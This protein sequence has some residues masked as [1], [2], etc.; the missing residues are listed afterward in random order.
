MHW[1]S[2][3]A[4][5]T[6]GS[7]VWGGQKS[8]LVGLFYEWRALGGSSTANIDARTGVL[9][10]AVSWLVGHR[11]P[12][13]HI[14]APAPGSSVTSDF[15]TIRYSI[16]PDSGRAISGRWV[17]YSL[18]GGDTWTAAT[19]AVCADSGCI[20]DLAGSLGGAPTPNSNGVMLRVRVADDGSPSLSSNAE[21]SA[22]FTL[23]RTGGD[24]RGPVLVAG[25][26]SCSP[27][28]IH[29][30]RPASLFATFSDAAMGGGAVAAA[31][32]SIGPTPTLAGSGTP[33]SGAFGSNTTVSVS[34]ALPTADVL[35][36]SMTLWMRGRDAAGNWGAATALTVP[37]TGST[38]VAVDEQEHVDFLA[39]PSPNPFRSLATIRFGLARSAE[40]RLELFDVTGRLVQTLVS[41]VRA[42]GPHV[43]TWNGQDQR[44]NA[45][46]NGVYFVRLT[47]PLKQFHARVVAL[48]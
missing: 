5:G 18:D 14:T 3:T 39:T 45:V 42:A 10:D 27:L 22:P 33:M 44:G 11:P 24:T 31:E 7:G 38:T 1:E 8:R 29:R 47:T 4:R 21:M 26:A 15:L 20:W 35:S 19:T 9:Q 17:D 34:A 25:S 6:G 37:T 12:E 48:K 46:K 32:Y 41:G 40:V 23:V 43:A 13:V 30:G 36:G 28:P 16:R 2:N